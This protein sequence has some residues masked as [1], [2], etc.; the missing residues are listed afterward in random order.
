MILIKHPFKYQNIVPLTDA[1]AASHVPCIAL[2]AEFL[3]F[4]QAIS[5]RHTT[6]VAAIFSQ[7]SLVCPHEPDP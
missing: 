1:N 7:N 6:A 2:K 5:S 3:A 4:L